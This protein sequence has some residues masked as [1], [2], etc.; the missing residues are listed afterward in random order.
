[1]IRAGKADCFI[2]K[3]LT[4][5]SRNFT[6]AGKYLEHVLPF[7][8]CRFIAVND[9]IDSSKPKNAGDNIV[10]PFKNLVADAYLRD[11]S[12]KIRSQFETKRR[13][14]YFIGSFVS[15]GYIKDSLDRHK[16]VV[17]EYAA[18]IVRMIFKWRIDG[19]SQ[20]KIAD[21]LNELGV[22]S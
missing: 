16:I 19:L 9:G 11:I 5:F 14:G 22:L 2:C 1:M 7:L 8:G 15:F 3:D 17:D 13:K 6:E 21:K 20:L 10:I 12:V 4:R 18:E